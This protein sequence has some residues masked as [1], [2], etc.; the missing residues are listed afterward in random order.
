[1]ALSQAKFISTA[2]KLFAKAKAGNLTRVAV[3]SL[4]GDYD[5]LTDIIGDPYSETVDAII[6]KYNKREIDGQ[7]VQ[8]NDLKLLVRNSQL[9]A[10]DPRTDGMT[11]SING[12]SLTIIDADIDPANAVWTIQ[13][14]GT[15]AQP[16]NGEAISLNY[17]ATYNGNPNTGAE[18]IDEAV[19]EDMP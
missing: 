7:L 8:S 17:L 9:M 3:F 12:S 10:I 13:V 1:M 2:D 6:E 5:P 11:L 16:F 14:R 18:V 15:I 4:P 19:N